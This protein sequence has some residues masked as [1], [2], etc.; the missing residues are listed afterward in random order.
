VLSRVARRNTAGPQILQYQVRDGKV[1]VVT[2]WL[3]GQDLASYLDTRGPG[4]FRGRV[5]IWRSG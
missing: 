3:P 1:F 4:G 2:T 5:R